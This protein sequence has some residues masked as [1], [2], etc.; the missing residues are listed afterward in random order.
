MGG[1]GSHQQTQQTSTVQQTSTT[2]AQRTYNVEVNQMG[3][4]PE[5][6]AQYLQALERAQTI[7]LYYQGAQALAGQG[8]FSGTAL[9]IILLIFAAL[10]LRR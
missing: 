1:G 7:G 3:L 8:P 2:N 6:A 5:Q 4:Q 10:V 9:V